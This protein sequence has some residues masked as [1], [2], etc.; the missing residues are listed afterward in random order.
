MI[1]VKMLIS[2]SS[3]LNCEKSREGFFV[4]IASEREVIFTS[5]QRGDSE[6]TEI[7]RMI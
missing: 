4:V 2:F 6:H 7:K 5:Q 3:V 1:A